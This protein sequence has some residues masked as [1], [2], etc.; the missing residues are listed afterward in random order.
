MK[1]WLD[2][3][4][5]EANCNG[6]AAWKIICDVHLWP[7]PN[8]TNPVGVLR[9]MADEPKLN[10]FWATQFWEPGPTVMPQNLCANLWY[11]QYLWYL[12]IIRGQNLSVR[13]CRYASVW[14]EPAVKNPPGQCSDHLVGETI[15]RYCGRDF[16]S[17]I[18]W[19]TTTVHRGLVWRSQ[20]LGA[21]PRCQGFRKIPLYPFPCRKCQPFWRP[22]KAWWLA[23]KIHTYSTTQSVLLVSSTQTQ[24]PETPGTVVLPIS[25]D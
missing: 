20:L 22:S 17:P 18:T 1:L 7:A 12:C 19:S 16:R 6:F 21:W 25:P 8:V 14:G 10:S 24:L 5:S 9:V 3:G 11:W 2:Q 13:C 15:P 4:S 23:P